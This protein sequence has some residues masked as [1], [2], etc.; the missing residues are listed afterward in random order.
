MAT[1]DVLVPAEHAVQDVTRAPA[2]L[3]AD[4]DPT[5]QL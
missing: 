4:V 3:S 2:A 1:A 5:G